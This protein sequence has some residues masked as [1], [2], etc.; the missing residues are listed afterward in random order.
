MA[1][2][3]FQR[4]R[5]PERKAERRASILSAARALLDEGGPEAATLSAIASRA[6]VVKSGLYRYFESR[7]EILIQLLIDGCEKMVEE[8][9]IE[10]GTLAASDAPQDQ[11]L[12]HL[13]AGTAACFAERPR[14]CH[15][16]S[17]MAGTLEQNISAPK[18]VELKS[19]MYLLHQRGVAALVRGH[20]ALSA[21]GA[22]IAMRM[23]F[24]SV[25]GLWPMANPGPKVREAVEAANLPA[26]AY[27]FE[28][29]LR[30]AAYAAFSGAEA[31]ARCPEAAAGLSSGGCSP[32][33]DK[34]KA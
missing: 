16:V 22:E 4:A 34:G 15:L 30:C 8:L 6:G 17:I 29:A 1:D 21:E 24:T 13:A 10:A 3:G 33:V 11:R 31:A 7:E 28:D 9:E 19:A 5:S 32:R 14:L 20:G 12:L 23:I 25:A 18:I 27:D 26:F 2:D